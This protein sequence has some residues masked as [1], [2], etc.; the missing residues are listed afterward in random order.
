MGKKMMIPHLLFI[1]HDVAL[2]TIIILSMF[3]MVFDLFHHNEFLPY[4]CATYISTKITSGSSS[5]PLLSEGI[6]L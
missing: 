3:N 6:N 1:L 4:C 5:Q 2:H